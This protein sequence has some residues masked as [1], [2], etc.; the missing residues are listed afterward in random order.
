MPATPGRLAAVLLAALC[1]GPSAEAIAQDRETDL[2]LVLAV[3]VSGSM[4][5]DEQ[6]LQ[7]RGYVDAIR[8]PE[9]VAAIRSGLTG[10]IAVTYL[11]WAGPSAHRVLVPW[12]LIDG[13]EAADAFSARLSEAPLGTMRGTSISGGLLLAATLFDDNG[14]EGYRKVIDVSGD[15]PNNM[16]APVLIARDE[17]LDRGVV[18]NGLPIMLKLNAFGFSSISNLDEYYENCV[19]G[20]P[21]AFIVAVN[22]PAS[23]VE[24]I[25][26]KMILEIA[27]AGGGEDPFAVL[28]A[29][30][31]EFD[32]MIGERLRRQW[33]DR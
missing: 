18:I 21:G 29:S 23:L 16:G 22:D 2:E 11:E 24:S 13:Q 12:Q 1:L 3:D 7:R 4:D 17:V 15:G 33:L 31:P 30:D 32:C 8:D 5:R 6:V 14:F 26:R 25:R 27:D 9:V 10:S 19:I 20:G 28:P